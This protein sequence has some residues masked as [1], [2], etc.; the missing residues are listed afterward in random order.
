MIEPDEE[1][2]E[3]DAPGAE[4]VATPEPAAKGPTQ[5]VVM[6]GEDAAGPAVTS[7]PKR[8]KPGSFMTGIRYA[9]RD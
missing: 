7:Q 6:D 1:I 4:L 9:P 5:H 3:P 2:G 8:H